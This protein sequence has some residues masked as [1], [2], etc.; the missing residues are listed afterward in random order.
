MAESGWQAILFDLDGTLLE[1]NMDRFLD[2]YLAGMAEELAPMVEPDSLPEIVQQIVR[3]VL[4]DTRPQYTNEEVFWQ[5]FEALSGVGKQHLSPAV[6]A[7]HQRRLPQLAHLGEPAAGGRQA[8]N[9]ARRGTDRLV[10]ATQPLYPKAAIGE[11]VRWAGLGPDEFN[12][13]TTFENMSTCKPW[14]QYY[15]D[16]LAALGVTDPSRVLM[17]GNDPILDMAAG[18]V[19]V[20]TFL[21]EPPSGLGVSMEVGWLEEAGFDQLAMVPQPTY[22]GLLQE[23][24]AVIAKGP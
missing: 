2:E 13:I 9:A 14:P 7:F 20:Q 6:Q 17:V 10:L 18:S 23:V 11:R 12:F 22:Q 8:V 3:N 21:L 15:A 4:L 5:Q 16:I 1:V 24:P 19:G